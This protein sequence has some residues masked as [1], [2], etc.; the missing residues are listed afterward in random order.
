MKLTDVIKKLVVIEEQA[1]KDG[2]HISFA[3]VE[4]VTIKFE[5]H[6]NLVLKPKDK[7]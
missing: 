7:S 2:K 6:I 4:E 1:R 3:D 5:D